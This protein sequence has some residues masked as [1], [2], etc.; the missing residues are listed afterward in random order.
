MQTFESRLPAI[1]ILGGSDALEADGP[2]GARLLA[3]AA[4]AHTLT[5][6][7]EN[8]ADGGSDTA[9]VSQLSEMLALG[10]AEALAALEACGFDLEQAAA[11]LMA[12]MSF[13]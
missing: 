11:R 10:E 2:T 8:R 13:D 7:A 6:H 4:H 3:A 1:A 9:K 12:Q 5:L